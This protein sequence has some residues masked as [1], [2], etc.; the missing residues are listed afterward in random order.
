MVKEKNKKNILISP[1][2]LDVPLEE[3]ENKLKKVQKNI[4]YVHIDVMDGIFVDNH[5]DGVRMFEA[6]KNACDVPL[7]VHLM[8]ADLENEIEKYIG[9]EIITIHIEAL[10][11]EGREEEFLKIAQKIRNIGAKVGV[12]VRP[13]T[14]VSELTNLLEKIDLVLIM[15]VEPGYG[16]Q[17]LIVETLDKVSELRKIGFEKIIEV[18]GGINLKNI[19]LVKQY[20]ID[21]IVAG[22]AVFGATDE[23]EAINTIKRI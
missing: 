3:V 22:T 1:S 23:N 10:K 4:E 12:S 11:S 8:V 18:D 2:I 5:T 9:A 21:M 14:K 17:E 19:S 6:A 7:D 16:R 20:D 13:N 15:T